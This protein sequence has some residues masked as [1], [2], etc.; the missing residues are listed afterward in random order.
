MRMENG[1]VNVVGEKSLNILPLSQFMGNNQYI[2]G[3]T[4]K[5]LLLLRELYPYKKVK[6]LKKVFD[7]SEVAIISKANKIGLTNSQIIKKIFK[8]EQL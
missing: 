5:E 2:G 7:R 8:K 3:W 4:D 6:E 1:I